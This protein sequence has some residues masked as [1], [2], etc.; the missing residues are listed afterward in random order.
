MAT[1]GNST[2]VGPLTRQGGR[3]TAGVAG[4]RRSPHEST[5]D[6]IGRPNATTL[7][8]VWRRVLWMA[9]KTSVHES[10]PQGPDWVTKIP[11]G[12]S[13]LLTTVS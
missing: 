5:K 7:G 4:P 13:F 1:G 12:A 2:W 9:V 8:K 6:L 3:G 10:A 11:P